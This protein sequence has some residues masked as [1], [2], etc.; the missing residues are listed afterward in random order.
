MEQIDF[1]NAN[2]VKPN[3]FGAGIFGVV[4]QNVPPSGNPT[5]KLLFES[6]TI[7]AM[8]QRPIENHWRKNQQNSEIDQIEQPTFHGVSVSNV[9]IP[10]GL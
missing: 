7:L 4:L 8:P 5:E 3:D 1:A 9:H 2:R 10:M 6:F